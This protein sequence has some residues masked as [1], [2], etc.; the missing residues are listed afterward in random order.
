MI[1]EATEVGKTFKIYKKN[2]GFVGSFKS[3][4]NR[5]YENKSAVSSF[6]LSVNTGEIVGLLGPNGAGKT[7][8]MKMFSGIIVPS[9]GNLKILG[10][11]PFHRSISFRKQIAL[12]MG[13]KS[14]LWWDLPALDSFQ[15]LQRYYEIDK[16]VFNQRVNELSELLDVK[17][18]LKVHVR[19]L[20]LGERM[21]VELISCLLHQPKIIFLDEPTI[22]LD[23][24][25]QKK[26]REFLL[27]F[28]KKNKTTIIV[29]SHYMADIEALCPRV[30]LVVEGRKR[31]DGSLNNFE[32]VLGSSKIVSF[33]FSTAVSIQDDLWKG[34]QPKWNIEGFNV[35][36]NI[37]VEKVREIT[38]SILHN[39]PVSDFSTG[40]LPIEQVMNRLM[41]NPALMDN[42]P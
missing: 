22:G 26:I 12:V 30:V 27:E 25:A 42:L 33:T 18:L 31:F 38:A 20:S 28:H 16:K 10:H 21:K 19:R 9:C 4:F 36:L 15:L 32:K 24:I 13:Q 7:T 37:P 39:Y 40:K 5:E 1:I 11:Q 6:D 41:E 34:F 8:I 3:L 14:Q 23:L 17:K 35:E 2:P 29:T